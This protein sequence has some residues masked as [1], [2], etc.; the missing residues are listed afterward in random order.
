MRSLESLWLLCPCRLESH[1]L[2]LLAADRID[3]A[4]SEGDRRDD[5]SGSPW[6]QKC[7]VH[8]SILPELQ[9]ELGM[10]ACDF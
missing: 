8:T 10:L 9:A 3:S 1:N 5:L 7:P 6:P 4:Q 2:F